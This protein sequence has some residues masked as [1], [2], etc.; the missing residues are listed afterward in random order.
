MRKIMITVIFTIMFFSVADV[1]ADEI[2]EQMKIYD[3]SGVSKILR[4]T[5]DE[6]D[7]KFEDIVIKGAK[8]E[9]EFDYKK[10]GRYIV[11]KLFGEIYS[12]GK[13]MRNIIIICILSVL[14]KNMT[15]NFCTKEVSETAFYSCYM[16]MTGLLLSSFSAGLDIFKDCIAVICELTEAAV[17]LITGVMM[18]SGVTGAGVFSPLLLG[19]VSVLTYVVKGIFIPLITLAAVITIINNISQRDILTKLSEG[20]KSFVST[21]IRWSAVIF[22]GF[23]VIQRIGSTGINSAVNKSAKAVVNMVP[24]VGDVLSGAVESVVYWAESIKSGLC[25]AIVIALSAICLI[26]VIKIT[27]L[28]IIYKVTAIII[29]PICDKRITNCIDSMGDHTS[30]ILSAMAT[31]LVMF[32][33]SIMTIMSISV[34]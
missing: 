3:F 5:E 1:Y 23:T 34:I 11:K 4:E 9:I 12:Y 31:V 29:Q 17:P 15:G 16:V 19:V 21:G 25:V 8:G 14:L 18:T 27:A 7:I 6:Y 2:D 22:M 13:I 24:M 33:F 20:I 30:V 26:P 28:I 10:I 32:I